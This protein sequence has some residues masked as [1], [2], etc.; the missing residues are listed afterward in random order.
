MEVVSNAG[1]RLS[2]D[3]RKIVFTSAGAIWTVGAD[4]STPT[5]V[6]AGPRRATRDHADLVPGWT[7]HPLRPRSSRLA[8]RRQQPTDEHTRRRQ[9]ARNGAHTDHHESGLE[10]RARLGS[11][12]ARGRAGHR[13]R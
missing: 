10:T 7:L 4:G 1:G 5:K 12:A 3:G 11:L 8:R 2:P 6:F 9:R 13:A